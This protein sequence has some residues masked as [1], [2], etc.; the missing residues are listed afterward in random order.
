MED[1]PNWFHFYS[2]H[3]IIPSFQC[4]GRNKQNSHD[5]ERI[6]ANRRIFETVDEEKL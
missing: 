3:S 6:S 2:Q 4:S 5:E 1:S